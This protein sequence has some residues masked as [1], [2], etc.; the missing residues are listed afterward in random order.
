M[1]RSQSQY[2]LPPQSPLQSGTSEHSGGATEADIDALV[3]KLGEIVIALRGECD[4]HSISTQQD[5][6][7][8][9]KG[10]E[11]AELGVSKTEEL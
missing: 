6:L 2:A 7:G 3:D 9:T 10:M 8:Q 1:H 4:M 5:S 11:T